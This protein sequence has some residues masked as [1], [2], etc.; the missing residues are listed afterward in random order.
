MNR[1]RLVLGTIL[2]A[3]VGL[4]AGVALFVVLREDNFEPPVAV[5]VTAPELEAANERQ[6]VFR[7]DR[8]RSVA[9]YQAFEEF[10]DATVGSPVGE[11]SAI[12][13]DILIE[14]GGRPVRNDCRQR[15]IAGVGEP[16]EGLAA[17]QGF[18]RI[19]QLS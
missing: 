16:H 1:R 4:F 8:N 10:L 13:G 14:P 18:S 7:I 6:R 5:V 2:C 17:A 3:I 11:T 12:A 15:G 19:G 9:R